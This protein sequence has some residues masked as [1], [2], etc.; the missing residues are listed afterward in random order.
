MSEKLTPLIA[1][2]DDHEQFI[3]TGS[4]PAP[5]EED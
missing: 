1:F 4:D 5:A 2:N 3:L